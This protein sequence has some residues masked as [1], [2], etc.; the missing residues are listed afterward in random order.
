MNIN[1]IEREFVR[2]FIRKEKKE[3]SIFKLQ[4]KTK[5]A[6]FL[7]KFNHDWDNMLIK[8]KLIKIEVKSDHETFIFL[9]EKLNLNNSELCYII[10]YGSNDR[11]MINFKQAFEDCQASGYAGFIIGKSGKKFYLKTEQVNGTPDRFIGIVS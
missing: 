1:D 5:R 2:S 4:S 7:D 3:R 6:Q 10:S 8:K 9:K 11:K